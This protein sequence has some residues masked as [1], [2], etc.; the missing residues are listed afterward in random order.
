MYFPSARLILLVFLFFG[1]YIGLLL[2][3]VVRSK[4]DLFDFFMLATLGGVP[5]IFVLAPDAVYFLAH[6][7]GVEFPF[8]LLFGSL[9]FITFFM[10]YRLI[11]R[12]NRL[13]QEV[14]RLVQ[15][16]GLLDER[17][18]SQDRNSALQS[19]E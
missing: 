16:V 6:L 3:R 9:S 15:E 18:R 11:R 8:L 19:V 4:I 10:L 12:V 14:V 2:R 5:L 7:I 13:R 17:S 1:L